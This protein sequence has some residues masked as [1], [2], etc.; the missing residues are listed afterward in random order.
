MQ[1]GARIRDHRTQ[2]GMSQDDLAMRVYVSRQTISSRENDKT[3]PDVQSL[4]LL[5]NL[6]EVSVDSLIKGDVEEM[7]SVITEEAK[8]MNKLATVMVVCGAAAVIWA[9]ATALMDLSLPVILVPA[10]VVFVPA[11]VA[12]GMVEKIKHDN[13]LFTYKSIEAFMRGEDPDALREENQKA[14]R[15][16]W[17]KLIVKTLVAM[18]VGFCCGWGLLSIIQKLVG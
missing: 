13:Q 9:V 3:Y 16:W 2:V 4:L 14:G 7:K 11:A 6:F 8:R 10:L 1:I 5:S 15:A 18:I 17:G 12:A